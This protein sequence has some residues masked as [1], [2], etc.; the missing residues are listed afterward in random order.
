[1]DNK[2]SSSI[3]RAAELV[4]GKSAL[5]RL[6]GVTPP[7]VQQWANGDR[8]VPPE[9]CVLVE[10]VTYGAV[11]RRDLRPDD[12]QLIWPELMTDKSRH[13]SSADAAKD[14]EGANLECVGGGASGDM[15]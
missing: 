3:A 4:G 15:Q 11:G 14:G 6:V 7:T 5:A 13:R 8:P 10:R 12:W 2:P 1:M 9:R